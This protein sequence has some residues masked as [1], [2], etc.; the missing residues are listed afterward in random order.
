MPIEERGMNENINVD[1]ISEALL[2]ELG[3]ISIRRDEWNG[4]NEFQKLLRDEVRALMQ[5]ASRDPETHQHGVQ[6]TPLFP[7]PPSTAE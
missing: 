2:A 6:G 4:R 3:T 5:S 7:A 1:L